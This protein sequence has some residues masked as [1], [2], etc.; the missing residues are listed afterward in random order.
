M[1]SVTRSPLCH[2]CS[3]VGDRSHLLW[4]WSP[5]NPRTRLVRARS[6]VAMMPRDRGVWNMVAMWLLSYPDGAMQTSYCRDGKRGRCQ[7]LLPAPE[8]FR[9]QLVAA[10]GPGAD[11]EMLAALQHGRDHRHRRG[12]GDTD[13]T[14]RGLIRVTQRGCCYMGSQGGHEDLTPFHQETCT[15]FG[16]CDFIRTQVLQFLSWCQCQRAIFFPE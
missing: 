2:Y 12:R 5:H 10:H 8:W 13:I 14:V 3:R 7:H 1:S 9:E 4:L 6:N 16:V 11:E 15:C